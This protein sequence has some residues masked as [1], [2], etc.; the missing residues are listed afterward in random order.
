MALKIANPPPGN[1]IGLGDS[2]MFGN[3]ASY[4]PTNSFLP[5]LCHDLGH[6]MVNLAYPG[7]GMLYA[8]FKFFCTYN[9]SAGKRGGMLV[10]EAGLNDVLK[11]NVLSPVKIKNELTAILC[12][13]FAATSVPAN[14][15][16]APSW[17]ATSGFGEKAVHAAVGG[18]MLDTSAAGALITGAFTGPNVVLRSMS[19][20]GVPANS[21]RTIDVW[22]DDPGTYNAADRVLAALDGDFQYDNNPVDTAYSPNSLG[23]LAT[24]I[25]G[26]SLGSHTFAIKSGAPGAG[27]SSGGCICLVDTVDTL[28]PP[29]LCD[30]VLVYLPPRPNSYVPFSPTVAADFDNAD[31]EIIAAIKVFQ[32]QGYSIAVARP[33]D[34]IDPANL[35]SDH[36]HWLNA[37]H[38][39]GK[40][41]GLAQMRFN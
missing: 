11:G 28:R 29:Y 30:P 15:F 32:D 20:N 4:P 16:T 27:Y 13:W 18:M 17:S 12:D 1:A 7:T 25:F 3:A 24:P 10:I 9:A 26:R 6:T 23:H 36:L 2:I 34:F 37:G 38:M 33:N 31:N 5:M 39:Q 41:A 8:C 21:L 22:I 19:N 35:A 40:L 14:A